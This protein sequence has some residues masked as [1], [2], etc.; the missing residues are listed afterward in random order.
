MLYL[1]L[2]PGWRTRS[3]RRSI[4]PQMEV[5]MPRKHMFTLVVLLAAAAG[6]GVLA[7]SRTVDLGQAASSTTDPDAAISYRLQELDRFEASLRKQ[8]AQSPAAPAQPRTVYRRA[9]A[10]PAPA[11]ASQAEGGDDL[12]EDEEHGNDDEH[13]EEGRDD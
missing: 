1:P 8:L 3:Y 2:S 7:L 12:Y 4:D 13:E 10:P 11:A 9:S 5:P 6:A